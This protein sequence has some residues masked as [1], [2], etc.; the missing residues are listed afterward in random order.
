MAHLFADCLDEML[1]RLAPREYRFVSL[2]EAM[3]D[4]TYQTKD[5][6]VTKYRPICSGDGLEAKDLIPK[7]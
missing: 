4:P 3:S 5:T 1:R 7:Q 2:E 6:Y